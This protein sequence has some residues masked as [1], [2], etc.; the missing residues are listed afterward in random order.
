MARAMME[1]G[2]TEEVAVVVPAYREEALLAETVET[3]PQWVKQVVIVDDGSPDET[4]AVASALSH[5]YGRVEVIRLGYNQGVG[6]AIVAGYRWAMAEGA[7]V[8]AV[9]AADAQMDPDDL[10]AVVTPVVEGEADYSKGNRLDHPD[11]DEMPAVRRLGTWALGGLTGWVS[12]YDGLQDSQCGYTAISTEM[13]QELELEALYPHYGYPNDLLIRLGERGARLSQPVVRPVYGD[14]ESGLS[15]TGVIPTISAI[16][17]R[18]W[19][20]RKRS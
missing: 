5:E 1:Q 16:L 8:V 20:R 9:M 12:G 13:L 7:T 10:E 19:W 18:G 15:V 6:A 17:M 11:I 2:R 4:Y 3:I 14:E